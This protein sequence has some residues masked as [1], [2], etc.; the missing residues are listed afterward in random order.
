MCR[1]LFP[2][3]GLLGNR[4]IIRGG[5][6][7]DPSGPLLFYSLLSKGDRAQFIKMRTNFL[8]SGPLCLEILPRTL[9]AKSAWQAMHRKSNIIHCAKEKHI[10]FA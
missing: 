10:N 4:A 5:L 9:P 2:L 8:I 7:P 1:Q 3:S 6:G